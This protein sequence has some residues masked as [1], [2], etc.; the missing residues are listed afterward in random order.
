[1]SPKIKIGVQVFLTEDGK[2]GLIS[3]SHNELTVMGLLMKGLQI[4]QG[5]AQI[6]AE[7]PSNIILP[8]PR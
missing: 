5:N 1:M 4:A 3:T 7:E 2:Y 8:E 6:K